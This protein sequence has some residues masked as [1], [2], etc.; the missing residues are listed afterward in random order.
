M[1]DIICQWYNIYDMAINDMMS[2]I[3][4]INDMTF[5]WYDML[6]IWFVDDMTC[7]WFELL[8]IWLV[9]DMTSFYG[10]QWSDGYDMAVDYIA[11][12]YITVN[13]VAVDYMAVNDM[14]AYIC[15]IIQYVD[16]SNNK[17]PL[18]MFYHPIFLLFTWGSTVSVLLYNNL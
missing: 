16:E 14:A 7:W 1:D 9:D 12:D 18:Y 6:M 10:C 15:F 4:L 13:D 11:V 17:D 8:M 3:W 5:R 2:L